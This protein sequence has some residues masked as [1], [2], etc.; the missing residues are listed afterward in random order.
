MMSEARFS[1]A[2]RKAS[3]QGQFADDGPHWLS[4]SHILQHAAG[5]SSGVELP[6]GLPRAIAR[7]TSGTVSGEL[8]GSM[9]VPRHGRGRRPLAEA[10][11]KLD[12][13]WWATAA[14]QR[15]GRP[16]EG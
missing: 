3:C 2:A 10:P 11:A 5:N 6:H 8:R 1:R 12:H 16:G 7:L 13:C 9:Y 4:A 14:P 15:L